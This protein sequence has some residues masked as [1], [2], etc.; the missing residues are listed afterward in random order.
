MSINL[1]K[2]QTVDLR[3]GDGGGLSN[4]RMGL[5][6]DARVVAKK[7]LFG[8]SKSV[9]KS[10]DLDASAILFDGNGDL[11]ETVFFKNLSSR[12]GSIKHTGDNL[13]GAGDGDDESIL[14]ALDRIPA[15]IQHVVFVVTSYSGQRFEE[16]ENAYVRV[17]DSNQSDAELAR[18][19]LSGEG[20]STAMTMARVSRSG[21]GWTFTAVGTP[22]NGRTAK[23]LTQDARASF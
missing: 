19:S 22:G 2:G 20:Q 10:I 15:Q 12:D 1:N 23:D 17:V 5:G 13:T 8:G 9:Q 7:G 3:K 14:V 6:W 4:V 18:Y 16:I 21:A 11:V